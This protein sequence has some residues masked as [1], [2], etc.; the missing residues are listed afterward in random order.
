MNKT[1]EIRFLLMGRLIALDDGRVVESEQGWRSGLPDGWSWLRLFGLSRRVQRFTADLPTE[2]LQRAG[3]EALRHMGHLLVMS[4]APMVPAA[5]YRS[6][7][8]EYALLTAEMEDDKLVL[9]AFAARSPIGGIKCRRLLKKCAA[10]LPEGTEAIYTAQEKR[11]KREKKEK[12]A[13]L[14]GLFH[15][16]TPEE[17]QAAQE[18]KLRAA[19]ERAAKKSA[20]RAEQAEKAAQRAEKQ[21][22]EAMRRAEEARRSAAAAAER[23]THTDQDTE[24]DEN[25]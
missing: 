9:T 4:E 14:G 6:W 17:K 25:H 10:F 24:N 19:E 15:R 23:R 20:K 5:L 11:E 3:I 21:A 2:E 18:A 16:K 12:K 7:A 8:T 22:A 1:E 13:S